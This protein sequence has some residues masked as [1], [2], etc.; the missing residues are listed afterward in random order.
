M[1]E[2]HDQ[3]DVRIDEV[4]MPHTI[5]GV[6]TSVTAFM[7]PCGLGVMLEPT[8][9]SSFLD[10]EREFGP[11]AVELPMGYAIRDFFVN[12]GRDAL[13]CR[14]AG[15]ASGL[16][17]D[18]LASYA[19][20]FGALKLSQPF[21]LLCVPPDARAGWSS[22]T[23]GP[24]HAA[25]AALC[26]ERRAMFLVD[27]PSDFNPRAAASPLAIADADTR[28]AAVYFPYVMEE[29]PLQG[30]AQMPF[31]PCGAVA[32]V[33]ARIDRERGVWHAPGGV[34]ASLLGV[35]GLAS[36]LNDQEMARLTRKGI[37]CLRMFPDSGAVVWA[38]RTLRAGAGP[39][40]EY[41][42]ISVRRLALFLESSLAAGLKWAFVEANDE[43]LWRQIRLSTS[44]FFQ[45]LFAQG[46]FQGATPDK[47]FFVKCDGATTT[48]ED[49]ARGFVRVIVGFAPLRPAEFVLLE[50]ELAVGGSGGARS[51]RIH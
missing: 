19:A 36:S 22:V 17:G 1:S 33:I 25:A 30:L 10:F 23:A 14:T 2:R 11:L 24:I 48:T 35:T 29:D 46:A 40:E 13:I 4:S 42:Y 21:N 45:G 51:S 49:I 38:A 20:G 34:H 8:P 50:I 28:N 47:A 18:L 39:S 26:V 32:G 6:A 12:G 5:E 41:R 7:G 16:A 44:N 31:A 27:P 15:N 37:N 43:T 3:P 9:I